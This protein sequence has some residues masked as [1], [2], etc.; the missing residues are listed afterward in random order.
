MH[1]LTQN[2]I[3]REEC[4]EPQV[5]IKQEVI[6]EDQGWYEEQ[7]E[8]AE[9]P[10]TVDRG[11]QMPAKTDFYNHG[12][13]S[14]ISADEYIRLTGFEPYQVDKIYR[15]LNLDTKDVGIYGD[16]LFITF[17]IYKHKIPLE[18]ASTMFNTDIKTIKRIFERTT[19]TL[20]ERLNQ[21]N[22]WDHRLQKPLRYN[23]IFNSI[24]IQVTRSADPLIRNLTESQNMRNKSTF[25]CLVVTDERDYIIFCSNLYGGC[26]SG[27]K[28]VMDSGILERL[29]PE[30]CILTDKEFIIHDFCS[31]R[32]IGMEIALFLNSK[33]PSQICRAHKHLEDFEILVRPMEEHFW[34]IAN[35][36]MY[37]CM[38]LM[39][40]K[41]KFW[42]E[43]MNS[44]MEYLKTMKMDKRIL[45][46]LIKF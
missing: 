4:E 41:K 22:F 16:F 34:C 5:F 46:P 20:Y 36:I 23:A 19:D 40:F 31:A 32:N 8:M 43:G 35:K 25:K 14:V 44:Q 45:S 3:K 29:E 17:A 6:I 37:N 42:K 9:K 7:Q 39:N 13:L 15:L 12:F 28:I 1:D 24:E 18:M 30:D 38:M 27:R 21:F 11:V 33:I 2:N 10:V 26:T